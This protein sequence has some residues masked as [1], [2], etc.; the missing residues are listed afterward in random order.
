MAFIAA[1]WFSRGP[2]DVRRITLH[3]GE[4]GESRTAAE[5]IANFFRGGTRKASAHYACDCDSTVQMVDDND[6]AWHVAGD[7]EHSI[8]IEQAGYA[9][10]TR[11]QWL[12]AYGLQMI[13]FQVAPLV[14]R[15][16]IAHDIPLVLLDEG[17]VKRN[18][19][20]VDTHAVV[21]RALRKSTHWDPGPNYPLDVLMQH[22]KEWRALMQKE[23]S[24]VVAPK[25]YPAA[26]V[27]QALNLYI[28]AIRRSPLTITN[29][30]GRSQEVVF[31]QK[32]L[33]KA[34]ATGLKLDGAFGPVDRDV[35]KVFQATHKLPITGVVNGR[36]L[37]ALL[38]Q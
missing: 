38:A 23:Q 12:D 5:G 9:S 34:G 28:I 3:D 8:G 19:K 18:E 30:K 16:S 2:R 1:R 4:V 11:D 33:R 10:Q 36:T 6:I 26:D 31:V 22:A 17:A 24:T 7:N 29:W 15:L 25:V 37:D 14:A 27:L 13:V 21:S 35:V 32:L 20:G